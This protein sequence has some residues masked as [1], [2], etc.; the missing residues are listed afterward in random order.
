MP[1]IW[2]VTVPKEDSLHRSVYGIRWAKD[3]WV[4]EASALSESS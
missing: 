1:S 2:L 4:E 3:P